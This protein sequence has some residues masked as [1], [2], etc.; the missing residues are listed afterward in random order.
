M[1]EM[2]FEFETQDV[3]DFAHSDPSGIGHSGSRKKLVRLPISV[4]KKYAQH[5]TLLVDAILVP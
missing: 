5:N 3:L 1:R 2:G 4:E